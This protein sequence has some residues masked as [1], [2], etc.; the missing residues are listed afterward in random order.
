MRMRLGLLGF[1]MNSKREGVKNVFFWNASVK[2]VPGL[3]DYN[4]TSHPP[5]FWKG[6]HKKYWHLPI[7]TEIKGIFPCVQTIF[8]LF[9]HLVFWDLEA[10]VPLSQSLYFPA[11]NMQSDIACSLTLVSLLCI[12]IT[13][14]S[15]CLAWQHI[16]SSKRNFCRL[17]GSKMKTVRW[18][19]IPC[20]FFFHSLLRKLLGPQ[21]CFQMGNTQAFMTSYIC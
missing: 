18:I 10:V 12:T 16:L 4:F 21:W 3:M 6:F 17:N 11:H 8:Q 15:P 1:H 7:E 9:W 13:T 2:R 5:S 19:W 20:F 14:T